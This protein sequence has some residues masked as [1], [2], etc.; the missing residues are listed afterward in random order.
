MYVFEKLSDNLIKSQHHQSSQHQSQ[1]EFFIVR[2]CA[3]RFIMIFSEFLQ[4][5]ISLQLHQKVLNPTKVSTD[6]TKEILIME[7]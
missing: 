7:S 1:Q 6:K 3:K 2:T 4:F 5:E